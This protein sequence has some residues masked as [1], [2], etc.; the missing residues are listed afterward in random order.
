[1]KKFLLIFIGLFVTVQNAGAAVAIKKAPTVA[2]KQTSAKDTGASL[3]PTV[4][5]LVSGVQQL[6]QKQKQLT[7]EC[8]PT[9]QELNW[10]NNMVK[11]WAKT[12]AASKS[13][14]EQ[15]MSGMH[16]C[17]DGDTY[18]ASVRL[19]ADTD[20]TDF[21]CYDTFVANTDQ[22]TVWYG[23]PKATSTY[24]CSDGSL[25]CNEKKRVN[26]SN[27]YDVFNL[28]DFSEADYTAS[29]LTMASKL[30]AKIENCSNAKLSAKKRAMWG[31]FLTSSLGSMGQKTN[32][33]N[34]MQTVSGVTS[35]MGGGFGGAM[36]SL[37]GIASQF[38]P[39]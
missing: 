18:E 1:M 33:G 14:V 37:S 28:I 15:A 2:T 23:Y 12:G 13:E 38:L 17:A 35:N 3:L 27:I 9:S 6:N 24:Y 29:E 8:V 11:E 25:S 34:I 5:N 31:E 39:Q 10:V 20:E 16:P 7:A 36:Q 30:M 26:V 21:I 19:A 32:T 22:G 4:M